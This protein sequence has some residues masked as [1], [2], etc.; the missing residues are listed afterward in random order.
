[1]VRCF[2]HLRTPR[3]QHQTPLAREYEVVDRSRRTR[4]RLP[5]SRPPE[6]NRSLIPREKRESIA[7][8][9]PLVS[10]AILHSANS[11]LA[12]SW[13]QSNRAFSTASKPKAALPTALAR[14]PSSGP[15]IE[16]ADG[17]LLHAEWRR[18]GFSV[19]SFVRS[20]GSGTS[21]GIVACFDNARRMMCVT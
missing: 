3:P 4:P 8:A 7:N 20:I 17:R 10:D 21:N 14:R 12:P 16:D 1:M 13:S 18:N 5:Y 11:F 9:P 6:S 2:A 15:W 19:L